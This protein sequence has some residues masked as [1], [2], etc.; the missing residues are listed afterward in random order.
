MNRLLSVIVPRNL[1]VNEASTML[2]NTL[3]WR[4]KFKADSILQEDFDQSVLGRVG[5]LHKTDKEGRAVTYNL[6]GGDINLEAVFGDV[7]K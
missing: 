7:D 6:Y 1:D 3:I 2:T 5:F 4:A